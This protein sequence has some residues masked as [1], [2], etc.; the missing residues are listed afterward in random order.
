[1]FSEEILQ[2]SRPYVEKFLKHPF[3]VEL[4]NATLPKEK[5]VFYLQQDN[6]FLA[7]MDKARK[8]LV[9]REKS[10][11]AKKLNNLIK[12]AYRHELRARRDLIA[13]EL[14]LKGGNAVAVPT[15]LAYTSYLIR[16]ACTGAFEEAFAALIPCPRLYTMIGEKYA[17]C[18][19]TSHPIYGK[20]LSIYT[21]AEMWK[22]NQKLL[23]ML[24][25]IAKP[26]RRRAMVESYMIACRYEIKFFDM[27][28]SLESWD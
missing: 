12:S 9:S 24:D 18:P 21:S 7:D 28:Y 26:S 11:R 10:D 3:L 14:D 27:A 4:I 8:I 19:A 13:K 25:T 20:W 2:L 23:E 5:F 22:W 1:M 6:I 16:L 15:T 17:P